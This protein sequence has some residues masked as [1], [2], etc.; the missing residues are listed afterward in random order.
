M[1]YLPGGQGVDL[2][3]VRHPHLELGGQVLEQ[4]VGL[5]LEALHHQP[6]TS[7]TTMTRRSQPA[8]SCH[9]F[10]SVAHGRDSLT[11][12]RVTMALPYSRFCPGAT[13][14]PLE[15]VISCMP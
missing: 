12:A 3:A 8:A 15:C 4:Q 6:T 1:T 10:T 5:R 9:P 14:P 11:G 7:T 2:V 13:L